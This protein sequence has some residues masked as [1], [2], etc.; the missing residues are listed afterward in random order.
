[1]KNFFIIANRSKNGI[2]EFSTAVREYIEAKGGKC[3]IDKGDDNDI[4]V[5]KN[6]VPSDTECIIVLGGDGTLLQATADLADLEIPFIGINLGTIGFLTAV[7]RTDFEKAIEQLLKDE[8]IIESRMMVAG[9][10]IKADDVQTTEKALNEIVITG[11]EPM[12][13]VLASV[14]VN[15]QLLHRYE[16]DGL[17]VATPTGSTGYSMSAGGPILKPTGK[18]IILTPICPHSMHN[19]SIVLA[20]DDEVIIKAEL[21]RNGKN[22]S[23]RV[24]FDGKNGISLSSGDNVSIRRDERVVNIVKLKEESFLATLHNKLK[25]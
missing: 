16:A 25:D 3:V 2:E 24:L 6:Q 21:D 5:I 18:N 20:E 12:Q 19:R 8:Y 23:L 11:N 7:E 10:I 17:I 22:Q 13:L 15:G 1:M 9:T 14:Y 4:H